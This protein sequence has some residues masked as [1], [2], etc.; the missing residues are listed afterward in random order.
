MLFRS[1]FNLFKGKDVITK[2]KGT[3]KVHII[4]KAIAK[5]PIARF[6][7]PHPQFGM[8]YNHININPKFSGLAK[9]PHLKLP[10][11]GLQVKL[12]SDEL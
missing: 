1:M 5:I 6:D 7:T 11:G 10:P 4:D 9:D 8:N 12:S 2:I 3:G